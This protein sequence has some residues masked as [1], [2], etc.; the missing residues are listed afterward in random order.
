MYY[1]AKI[2]Q[3]A[4]L[5]LILIGFLKNFPELMDYKTLI[6]GVCVFVFGWLIHKFMLK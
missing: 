2:I 5:T 6:A 3:A 4:G 1:C